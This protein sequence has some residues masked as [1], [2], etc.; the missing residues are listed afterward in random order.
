MARACRRENLPLSILQE[1]MPDEEE[2]DG[3]AS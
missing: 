3:E 2:P 1:D